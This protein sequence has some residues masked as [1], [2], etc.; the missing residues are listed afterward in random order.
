M[1]KTRYTLYA[2]AVPVLYFVIQIVVTSAA[3]VVIMFGRAAEIAASAADTEAIMA[4][5]NE[6]LLEALEYTMTVTLLS[7]AV[8]VGVM[9][10]IHRRR[11]M[12]KDVRLVPTGG[13]FGFALAMAVVS[14]VALNLAS[15]SLLSALPLPDDMMAQYQQ[16]IEA[17]LGGNPLVM[18]LGVCLVAP[19]IEELI[20]RGFTQRFLSE[21]MGPWLACVTQALIFGLFHGNAAQSAYAFAAAMAMGMLYMW[22]KSLWV[23][24]AFHVAYNTSS[25][26]LDAV[27]TSVYGE[28]EPSAG[29]WALL[30]AAGGTVTVICLHLAYKRFKPQT[31]TN[32]GSDTNLP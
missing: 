14:G 32:P 31:P 6:L 18:V 19:F 30:T 29:M 11:D 2:I 4:M 24:I 21:S 9:L 22:T 7:A 28:S 16:I 25:F 8:F 20:Y 26:G 17:T 10:I 13:G 5:M 1:S 23:T 3:M 27:L 12:W 15:S